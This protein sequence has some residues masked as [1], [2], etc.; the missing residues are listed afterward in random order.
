MK[1]VMKICV[2][3]A[4]V[5]AVVPMSVFAGDDE[6]PVAERMSAL[7]AMCE[8]SA[9]A[10]SGRHAESSLYERLGGYDSILAITTEVVRL[11]NVN[12]SIKRVMV[13]VD[14]EKLAKHVAD[15]MSAGTGGD[16][17][18]TG[19]DLHSSHVDMHLTDADFLSAGGDIITAMK[20]LGHGQEEIDEVVCIFVSLKD[21]VIT[22]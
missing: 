2:L 20:T 17:K 12:D 8:S 3:A 16:A 6:V 19:R 11:H 5:L 22:E 18:Y 7:E 15:F 9:E 4:A 1:K 14:D 10:R 21:Q 13:D